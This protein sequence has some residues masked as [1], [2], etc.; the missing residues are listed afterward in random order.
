MF[1]GFANAQ[2][3]RFRKN[4]HQWEDPAPIPLPVK[5]QFEHEDAVVLKEANKVNISWVKSQFVHL[6]YEKKIRI[7]L[8]TKEGV[9]RCSRVTIPESFDPLYD[10]SSVPNDKKNEVDRPSYFNVRIIEF[11]ARVI[12]PDGTV[13]PVRDALEIGRRRVRVDQALRYYNALSYTF[14]LRHLEPGDELELYYQ[15]EVPYRDNWFYYTNARLFF[16][17]DLPKQDYHLIVK[18]HPM[19]GTS[20]ANHPADSVV[21]TK[22]RIIHHWH[23]TDLPGCLFERGARP[24]FDLPHLVYQV[25]PNDRLYY[26]SDPAAL[27]VDSVP[28]WRYVMRL[29]EQ[30]AIWLQ[31]VAQKRIPDKQNKL[32][33]EFVASASRSD[34]TTLRKA[35]SAH[36][37]I[38]KNFE[39]QNDNAYFAGLDGGLERMGTYTD[40]RIIREISR[41]NLYAKIFYHLELPYYTAYLVDNRVA[42]VNKTYTSPLLYNE[43]AFAIPVGNTFVYMHPK[44][45]KFGYYADEL[46]FYWEN[47]NAVLG[48]VYRLF[49][50]MRPKLEFIRTHGSDAAVNYRNTNVSAKIDLEQQHINFEARVALSG[51]FSTM[52]RG[53]YLNAYVDSSVNPRYAQRLFEIGHVQVT[54]NKM[55]YHATDYPFKTELR[56][57]YKAGN[58]VKDEGNGVYA[59]DLRN[60]FNYIYL[61]KFDADQRQ[62][63][64]YT[65][66]VG[67]DHFKYY[68]E[69]DKGVEVVNKEELLAEL[70]NTLGHFSVAI[71][72]APGGIMLEVQ[73][74]VNSHRIPTHSVNDVATIYQQM[75]QLNKAVLRVKVT[76]D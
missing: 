56:L 49:G 43:F 29:R 64:F 35:M 50:E 70:N 63:P 60:W 57:K 18:Y 36:N 31:R 68:L 4:N 47:S 8:Q 33:Y 53:K 67:Q 61:E 55:T 58:K 75:E 34:T 38:A 14:V 21:R 9:E 11:E 66:F 5:K 27:Y 65:D 76:A 42:S 23:K 41:Y 20:I 1:I 72:D 17:S 37:A 6:Y 22:K 54:E 48:S 25:N 39:Y 24:H 45:N 62:L 26:Q 32:V 13:K 30:R 71:T 7:K 59:I 10:Y 12:K 52:T 46:P 74:K 69:F 28:Y 51:Q 40:K 19:L 3:F 16:H 44:K 15:Y 73:L 2:D